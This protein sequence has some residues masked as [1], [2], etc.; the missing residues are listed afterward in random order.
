MRT[1]K[2]AVCLVLILATLG[3]T[4]AFAQSAGD[5]IYVINNTE[6]KSGAATVGDVTRGNIL[7]VEDVRPGW[8]LVHHKAYSVRGWVPAQDVV[9]EQ[10]ALER[11]NLDIHYRPTAFAYIGRALIS[12]SRGD[13]TGALRDLDQALRLEPGN[14][15]AVH[16]RGVVWMRLSKWTQSIRDFDQ[17]LRLASEPAIQASAYRNR[18]IAHLRLRDFDKAI[19]DFD[20]NLQLDPANSADALAHRAEAVGF[21]RTDPDKA[22]A[23]ANEALRLNPGHAKAVSIRATNNALRG[24]R[25]QALADYDH[26]LTLD[27]Q[28]ATALDNRGVV[29]EKAGKDAQ[30]LADFSAAIQIDPAF[31]SPFRHRSRV[32]ERQNEFQK[33]EVDMNEYVRLSDDENEFYVVAL[34]TRASFFVRRDK[35]AAAKVDIDE[36]VRI[37]DHSEAESLREVAWFLATCPNPELRQG[38]LA[39]KL[40]QEACEL[41]QFKTPVMLDA[42]AAAYA[43]SGDFVKAIETDAKAMTLA[44]DENQRATIQVHLELYANNEPFRDGL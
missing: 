28:N 38:A 18:G 15:A 2:L 42:L 43:E 34:V 24:N 13:F 1:A 31:A 4:T 16:T 21:L 23:D 36:A 5:K 37:V 26:A 25:E 39:V 40:A 8:F 30:A 12:K 29:H 44:G 41:T 17:V 20:A 32:Y 27:P 33:A 22:L 3:G 35:L 14:A 11:F 6:L 19:A 9:P 7:K 10:V